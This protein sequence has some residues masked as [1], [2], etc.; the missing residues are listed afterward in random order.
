TRNNDTNEK[1]AEGN[2][3]YQSPQ[4][5]ETDMLSIVP[6]T[7]SKVNCALVSP[8]QLNCTTTSDLPLALTPRAVWKSPITLLNAV[9]TLHNYRI[10]S[11]YLFY[12]VILSS[13]APHFCCKCSKI[14]IFYGVGNTRADG[15]LPA[16]IVRIVICLFFSSFP[17]EQESEDE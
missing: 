15:I 12:R 17:P 8:S 10:R 2:S 14:Q 13:T 3:R 6:F 16:A 11:N 4:P 7:S 9:Q 5:G 1:M